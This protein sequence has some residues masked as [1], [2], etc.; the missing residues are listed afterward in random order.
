MSATLGVLDVRR[1]KLNGKINDA[2][3]G[4]CALQ[5]LNLNGNLLE[6]VLPSSLAN[7]KNLEVFDIGNNYIEDVF[8]C[9]MRNISRLRVLVLRSNKFYGAIGCAGLNITWPILQIVDLASNNFTGWFP[10]ISLSTWKAMLHEEDEGQSML[11]HLQFEVLQLN[12]FYYQDMITVTIKGLDIELVKIL[13]LFTSIDIS[14]NNLDGPIPKDI[15]ELKALYVLNLSHNAFTGKIPPS[16]GNLVQLESLDLSR[17]N[18]SGEIPMQ[19]TGLTFLSFLNLSFNQLVGPIPQG[20]Q[21]NTFSNNSYE[22]NMGLCGYPMTKKCQSDEA[23]PPPPPESQDTGFDWQF[24][25]TGLGFGVGAAV[26]VAP[27]MFWE[28]GR[29]ITPERG[30]ENRT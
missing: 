8:P 2:F 30:D 24:I 19:L 10:K 18:L 15:G 27:L 4:N 22:G 20:N 6:G 17:N 26:V 11:N 25:L 16:L 21:F 5:T 3:P 23:P 12:P 28:K 29:I 13:T 7:C 14:C 9:Y 1:N